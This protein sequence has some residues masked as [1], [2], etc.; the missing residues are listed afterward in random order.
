MKVSRRLF[1]GFML[2]AVG[3]LSLSQ[4]YAQVGAPD[5]ASSRFALLDERFL[6]GR[7]TKQGSALNHREDPGLSRRY[8]DLLIRAAD[9]VHRF[10]ALENRQKVI[11]RLVPASEFW[12]RTKAPV[13]IS[14]IYRAG[15]ITVPVTSTQETDQTQLSRTLRHEYVH[16]LLAEYTSCRCPAWFD[17]GLAQYVEGVPNRRL[18]PFLR[19]WMH[20]RSIIPF[21]QLEAEFPEHDETRNVVAYAQSLFAIRL[22][23]NNSGLV[24]VREYLKLIHLGKYPDEAFESAFK[25]PL[26]DFERLVNERAKQWSLTNEPL[27]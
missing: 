5:N 19:D 14:A 10:L 26:F 25:Q 17:E 6:E 18:T 24:A 27:L 20:K 12:R 9:E 3:L 13:W 1:A 23:L 16:A 7:S 8:F 2:L 11:L 21:S 4:A 22:L 15:E